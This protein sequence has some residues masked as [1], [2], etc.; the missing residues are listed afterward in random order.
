MGMA[1]VE[2]ILEPDRVALQLLRLAYMLRG[3]KEADRLIAGDVLNEASALAMRLEQQAT[4]LVHRSDREAFS[5]G[6][7]VV[8]DL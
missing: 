3:L 2:K 1:K 4:E 8:T 7:G 6:G 5:G